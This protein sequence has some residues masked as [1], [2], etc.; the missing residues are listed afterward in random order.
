MAAILTA[1]ITVDKEQIRAM[2]KELSD[3]YAGAI[4]DFIISVKD[5][6]KIAQN[7]YTEMGLEISLDLLKDALENHGIKL[8][9]LQDIKEG[10]KAYE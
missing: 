2:A 10:I 3:G 8:E 1:N 9:E 5:N 7:V 6:I 4:N